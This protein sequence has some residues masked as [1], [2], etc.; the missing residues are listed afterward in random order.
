MVYKRVLLKISGEALLAHDGKPIDQGFLTYLSKEIKPVFDAGVQ[1]AI[2]VGGGNIFRGLNANTETGLDRVTGD[3]M[4]MLGT[5]I[6]S[7]ALKAAFEAHGMPARA[8]T[9]IEINKVAEPF[10]RGKA[11][12]H[13]E[14]GRIVIFGAGTGNP[15]F[16]T[17]TAAALRA[18]EIGA[19]V[20][21]K[22]TKVD[23]LYDKDPAKFKDAV[24]I[25]K[26]TYQDAISR[27]L[28]VMD[29]TA[30]SLCEENRLP[31]KILN[32]FKEGN[33]YRGVMEEGTG[34]LVS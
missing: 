19:E 23:G 3:H 16:T 32:I 34:S 28:R 22:A 10:I 13:L 14:K 15:Y 9:A 6:N 20:L 26:T 17:D 12:R 33:I 1:I 27:K 11:L 4:G 30:L 5:V 29:M 8:M 31:I 2:V 21:I 18:A 7:L 25:E 24:F